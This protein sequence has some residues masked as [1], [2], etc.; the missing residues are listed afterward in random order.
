MSKQDPTW[1]NIAVA[2]RAAGIN[3][4]YFLEVTQQRLE[5][6]LTD[7]LAQVRGI[8]TYEARRIV[9]TN[10]EA[11]GQLRALVQAALQAC[12]GEPVAVSAE[13][14]RLPFEEGFDE[15]R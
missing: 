2:A 6:A 5:D 8:P 12:F 13:Q 14:L 9:L 10:P 15:G 4:D 11:S 3:I 1:H 7:I